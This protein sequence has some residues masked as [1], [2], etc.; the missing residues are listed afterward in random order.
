LT[1]YRSTVAAKSAEIASTFTFK[2][3]SAASSVRSTGAFSWALNTGTILS[4]TSVN[5][6]QSFSSTNIYDGNQTYSSETI[7]GAES[8]QSTNLVPTTGHW[9]ESTWSTHQ[10]GIQNSGMLA[11]LDAGSGQV[12]PAAI[13]GLLH[14]KAASIIDVGAQTLAMVATTHYRAIIPLSRLGNIPPAELA[15]AERVIGA[16]SFNVDFWIDSSGLLRQ[17]SLNWKLTAPEKTTAKTGSR[18]LWRHF[19]MAEQLQL[20]NYGVP[21]QVATPPPS[22]VSSHETCQASGTS[23]DCAGPS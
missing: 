7:P 19:D 22:D 17:L 6:V 8:G 12:N 20:S 13:L 1:A 3:T 18:P 4:T 10:V 21:V 14:A 11:L 15:K 5:G 16:R 2:T 23:I 9:D